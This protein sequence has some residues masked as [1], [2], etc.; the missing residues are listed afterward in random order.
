MRAYLTYA[1]YRLIG[2]LVGRLP[3]QMGY[4]LARRAGGLLYRFYPGLRQIV[5]D[6][7]RHVLGPQAG[8]QDV[9]ATVRQACTNIAKGH[10]ELFRL[11]RLSLDDIRDL[12]HVEGMEHVQNALDQGRGVVV[13]TAHMGNVDI[14]SQFPATFGLPVIGAAQHVKPERLFRYLMRVRQKYGLRLIPSDEPMIPLFRALKR[15]GIVA[16]P[17]D[18]DIADHG[19]VIEFF[20]TPTRL[21][22][23]PVRVALR[24]GAALIP[25]FVSRLADESFVIRVE[26]ELNLPHTGDVEADV[27]GGL[28]MVV[29]AMEQ[30]IVRNPAQWL[31][32]ARVWPGDG[33]LP[34]PSNGDHNRAVTP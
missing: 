5:T 18:R 34:A 6:N 14:V 12:V 27:R 21:P 16:L 1:T 7:M 31:V 13:T 32:A 11:P 17:S 26:P 28:E 24:T 2:A 23:G 10:Y 8:E 30:N 9:Q 25:A 33:S 19:Q 29:A 3:P 20:G 22:D 4:W 15:G